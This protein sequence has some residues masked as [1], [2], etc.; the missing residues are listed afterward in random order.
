MRKVGVTGWRKATPER[1]RRILRAFVWPPF[2]IRTRENWAHFPMQRLADQ[3]TLLV[4]IIYNDNRHYRGQK[5]QFARLKCSF[6]PGNASVPPMCWAEWPSPEPAAPINEETFQFPNLRP[7][8]VERGGSANLHSGLSGLSASR[9]PGWLRSEE[10][11][12]KR[13][14]RN[15]SL[16]FK[17]K[18]ALS[19]RVRNWRFQPCAGLSPYGNRPLGS[20]L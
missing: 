13:P 8:R 5:F 7:V 18:V 12:T 11:M 16:T 1:I 19:R 17:A 4:Y 14:R 3:R 15:H 10:T 2:S 9:R 6:I 20:P